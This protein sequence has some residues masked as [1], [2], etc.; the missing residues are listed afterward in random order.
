MTIENSDNSEQWSR[1]WQQGYITTFGASKAKNYDGVV[2]EFWREIFSSLERDSHILDI[3]T[4]NGA[5]AT[6]A[7][8]VSDEESKEYFVA[9][10]DLATINHTI[11]SDPAARRLRDR[12]TFHS[13][14]PCDKQPF[15]NASFDLVC[16]QFGFE[17]SDPESTLAEVSRVLRSGRRFVAISH[18]VD[19]RLIKDSRRELEVYRAALDELE[20]FDRLEDYFKAVGVLGGSGDELAS[21]LKAARPQS[22]KINTAV[23]E[24]RQRYPDDACAREMVAAISHLV[25]RAR[26]TERKELLK[27]L[28]N[29]RQEFVLAQARL[30]DMV[31]AALSARQLEVLRTHATEGMA[32]ESF[33][34]C[35]FPGEGGG[36]AGWQIELTRR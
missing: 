13:G 16:S 22:Q 1:F 26:G 29:A 24:F 34:Y 30:K 21:A 2:R 19:S 10:T 9:G 8:E 33:D 31:A 14:T 18:H 27:A 25:Q 7:A 4:G 28:L 35:E 36:P 23:N 12:I 17:Y 5:L 11:H 32:F 20:L 3:A 6:L 15:E